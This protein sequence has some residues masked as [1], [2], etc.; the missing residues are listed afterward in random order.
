MDDEKTLDEGGTMFS[1]ML[2]TNFLLLE[3]KKINSSGNIIFIDLVFIARLFIMPKVIYFSRK[4]AI[5]RDSSETLNSHTEVGPNINC[6]QRLKI[7]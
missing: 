4:F 5:C 1:T 2:I 7:T 3:I 6:A